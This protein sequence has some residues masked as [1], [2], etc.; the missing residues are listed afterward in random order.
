MACLAAAIFG[1]IVF[2]RMLVLGG[3]SADAQGF[4]REDQPFVY[5]SIV[6]VGMLAD[7]ALF[8]CAYLEFA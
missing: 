5:W 6:I 4:R 2:M 8:Y 1:L 7:A 3:A